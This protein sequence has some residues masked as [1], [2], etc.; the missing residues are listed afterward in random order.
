MYRI[1][2]GLLQFL[3]C[4][5]YTPSYVNALAFTDALITRRKYSI[6]PSTPNDRVWYFFAG[7][8]FLLVL[9]VFVAL[10]K[11][12]DGGIGRDVVRV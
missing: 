6:N 8:I 1:L 3:V 11:N 4:K 5:Q 9:V 2:V 12:G 7:N 10:D